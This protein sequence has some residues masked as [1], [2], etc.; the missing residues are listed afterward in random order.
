MQTSL[1]NIVDDTTLHTSDG[2]KGIILDAMAL[3]NGLK[4]DVTT[5]TCSD[6]AKI[7]HSKT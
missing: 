7:V 1:I 5:K 2:N 3:V 4:N 6:L